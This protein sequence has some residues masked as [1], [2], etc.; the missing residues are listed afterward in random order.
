MTGKKEGRSLLSY[1]KQEDR[2]AANTLPAEGRRTFDRR[3]KS[4]WQQAEHLQEPLPC[5]TCLAIGA[6][7]SGFILRYKDKHRHHLRQP[8]VALPVRLPF[9]SA[10]SGKHWGIK[11]EYIFLQYEITRLPTRIIRA[12]THEQQEAPLSA[13][14]GGSLLTQKKRET[15][16]TCAPPFFRFRPRDKPAEQYRCSLHDKQDDSSPAVISCPPS[17]R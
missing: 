9:L 14:T 15:P 11:R 4:F 5:P 13:V 2:Q 12:R 1:E 10:D 8:S 17:A 6:P 16:H 7:E 3:Q